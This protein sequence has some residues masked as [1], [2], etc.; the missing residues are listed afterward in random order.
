MMKNRTLHALIPVLL[1]GCLTACEIPF[2][3]EDTSSPRI[4]VHCV[5][6]DGGTSLLVQYAAPAYGNASKVFDF[7]PSS[8]VLTVNGTPQ[9]LIAE[10]QKDGLLHST[11]HLQPGDEVAVEVSAEGLP[12]ASGSSTVPPIPTISGWKL[13]TIQSDTLTCTRITLTLDHI[14][15]AGEYL[16]LQIRTH[17]DLLYLEDGIPVMDSIDEY[18]AP[19]KA[20]TDQ[21][22]ARMDLS[23]YIQVNFSDGLISGMATDE[24]LAI[25]TAD[26]FDGRDY[27]FYLDSPDLDWL[28]DFAGGALPGEQG[29]DLD[30]GNWSWLSDGEDEADEDPQERILL[31]KVT[32]CQL[33]LHRL[34]KEFYY[35]A[36][37]QYQSNFDFLSN[38]GLTPA[39]F[40]Y[41]NIRGG[42]GLIGAISTTCTEP[43]I[44]ETADLTDLAGNLPA[45]AAQD[46]L[47]R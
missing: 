6:A 4:F 26:Q 41:S 42:I 20:L 16:G 11:T 5:P 35:Y 7:H 10:G 25:L 9:T 13:E 8:V 17:T 33:I 21:E 23:D 1:L 40:T 36:K 14:P 30:S 18:A 44:I 38:M 3:L 29:W 28:Y 43:F 46:A 34:S 15:A 2:S 31:G 12:S 24:P 45:E 27:S 32:T 39:N 22:I 19:G 37:A 47:S